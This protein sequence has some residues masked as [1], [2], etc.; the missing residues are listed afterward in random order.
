MVGEMLEGTELPWLP[1]QVL[2]FRVAPPTGLRG[3]GGVA[4]DLP[5]VGYVADEPG[6]HVIALETRPLTVTFD[7]LEGRSTYRPAPG[8]TEDFC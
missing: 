2:S 7:D 6:L 5:A 3:L 8:S 1:H 4:G